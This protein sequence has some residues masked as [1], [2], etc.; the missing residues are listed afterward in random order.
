MIA[1]DALLDRA[2]LAARLEDLRIQGLLDP[3][4][5]SRLLEHFDALVRDTEEEK[6]KLASEYQRRLA[7]DGKP[8][9]DEWLSGAA[10]EFGRRQGEATRQIT[11]QLRV[12]TG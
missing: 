5:E 1:Q 6:A 10:Y 8:S 2:Q 7:D 3:A 4:E 11:E 12:V 9:A